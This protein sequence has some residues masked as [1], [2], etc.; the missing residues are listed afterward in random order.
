MTPEV[1]AITQA[2]V[3][4]LSYF[5]VPFSVFLVVEWVV[6]LFRRDH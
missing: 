3:D 6:S 4:L 2:T 1:V 5:L